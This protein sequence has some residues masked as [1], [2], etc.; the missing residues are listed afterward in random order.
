MLCYSLASANLLI[1]NHDSVSLL[2]PPIDKDSNGLVTY[3]ND[4]TYYNNSTYCNDGTY[5]ND[6]S[7]SSLQSLAINYNTAYLSSLSLTTYC[8]NNSLSSL[9]STYTEGA[10]NLLSINYTALTRLST[11]GVSNALI[12]NYDNNSY[13]I[14]EASK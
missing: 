11:D 8:N 5:Y 10:S 7:L 3:Y 9:P 12:I 14:N 1:F 4:G 6:G 13:S 2:S